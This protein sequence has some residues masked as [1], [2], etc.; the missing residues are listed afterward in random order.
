MCVGSWSHD[1]RRKKCRAL[2]A[3][4]LRVVEQVTGRDRDAAYFAVQVSGGYAVNY[5]SVTV[6]IQLQYL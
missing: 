5:L 6:R 1:L 3:M 2:Y 4:S